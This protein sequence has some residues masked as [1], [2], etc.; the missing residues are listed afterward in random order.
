MLPF[1]NPPI[2]PIQNVP[3]LSDKIVSPATKNLLREITL[4][5][6]IKT[7]YSSCQGEV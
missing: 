5:N 4:A 1:Y 3:V 7:V 2:M 6:A